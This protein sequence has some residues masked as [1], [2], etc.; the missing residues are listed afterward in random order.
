VFQQAQRSTLVARIIRHADDCAFGK[1][2]DGMDFVRI[3]AD[4]PDRGETDR[5]DVSAARLDLI[6][7]IGVVLEGVRVV[8]FGALGRAA[9]DGIDCARKRSLPISDKGDRPWSRLTEL[10][11]I[12]RSDFSSFSG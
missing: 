11:W 6:V 8:L 5:H 4:Q 9:P 7:E 3:E 1:V 12:R 2:G 10:A